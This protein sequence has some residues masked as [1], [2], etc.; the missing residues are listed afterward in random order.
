MVGKTEASDLAED[1]RHLAN[2]LRDYEVTHPESIRS[3]G[4]SQ[5]RCGRLSFAVGEAMRL[6]FGLT[7]WIEG[8]WRPTEAEIEAF[9]EN[10]TF[11]ILA[12]VD[13]CGIDLGADDLLKETWAGMLR[14]SGDSAD[15]NLAQAILSSAKTFNELVRELHPVWSSRLRREVEE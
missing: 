12:T 14:A 15:A 10:K 2:L 8:R 6:A 5:A 9:V 7:D 1:A 3:Q 4:G 13:D 11:N